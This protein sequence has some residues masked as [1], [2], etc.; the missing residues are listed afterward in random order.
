MATSNTALR[1]VLARIAR[2]LEDEEAKDEIQEL[3]DALAEGKKVSIADIRDAISEAPPEERAQLRQILAEEMD[4]EPAP[5]ADPPKP[6]RGK[7]ADPPTPPPAD[8][9]KTRPGRK[10]G[11]AY[12]WF[13]DDDGKVVRLPTATIYSG[14]DEPDEVEMFPDDEDEP[15]T[16]PDD[17]GDDQ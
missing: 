16:D 14:E 12:D 15:V 17:S 10:S 11:M 6:K 13:V 1:T 7:K 8:G 3:R 2:E 5:V 4:G 9:R